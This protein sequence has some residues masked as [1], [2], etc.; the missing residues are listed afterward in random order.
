MMIR[1]S[2]ICT[3]TDIVTP[4]ATAPGLTPSILIPG[5][6]VDHLSRRLISHDDKGMDAARQRTPV[7]RL[8]LRRAQP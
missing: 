3:A 2:S 1:V 7:I 4:L 5:G 6:G 8:N